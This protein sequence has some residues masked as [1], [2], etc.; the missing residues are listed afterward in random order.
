M[1][2]LLFVPLLFLFCGV[3]SQSIPQVYPEK[4]GIDSQKLTYADSIILDAIRNKAIPGAVLAVVKDGTIA[5]MKAYGNKQI[6]P[7]VISMDVNTVFDLASCTKPVATAIS[8]MILLERGQIR[9]QDK[10]SLYIPEFKQNKD[11][12]AIKKEPKI[13]DLFTHTSGFPSYAPVEELKQKY[14][15]PNPDALINYIATC[16]RDYVAETDFEY[17]CLNFITLQRIIEKVSGQSLRDFAKQ[18]IFDVLGMKHTDFNPT[19]E[20]LERVAPTEKQKDDTV[21]KG[22]VHDPLA[23]VM[24]GGISGNAGLFS[25][26]TDLAILV[27]AL[28]NGGEFNGKR[29]LSPLGVKTMRSIPQGFESFGRA[30][31]WD[32]SSDFASNKGNLFGSETYGHTGYTGTSIIID[33]ETKTSVILLTNRV[34]PEDKGEV[35][36]LRSK[37]ANIIAASIYPTTNSFTEHYYER[38][39]EFE[40][41]SPIISTDFVMIGNSLTEGGGDWN[42][43][44]NIS[45]MRNRG[46]IGDDAQGINNRLYQILPG[47]PKKIFLM[48]GINDLS[49]NLSVDSI[50]SL[51]DAMII[52][53]QTASP[54]TQIYLQSLLPINESF[55]KYKRLNDKTEL[56]PEINKKLKKVSEKRNITF[57]QLFP[58]F[59]EKNSSV[60]RKDLTSDGL[61]LNE[62]GY[63]IW[64][65]ELKQYVKTD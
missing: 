35:V 28:Q 49:H 1:K 2:K 27:S 45:N 12:F 61:H 52:K 22:I 15:A 41:E 16:K 39:A 60:L 4:V 25:D 20:T 56:I 17:S 19:G 5:Y 11:S 42:K 32:V 47:K 48:C 57:V 43:R 34:H 50:T 18:N 46:I 44:L 26:A 55:G 29:I 64:V 63:N 21:L 65:K 62:N 8:A 14:G 33:P 37:I 40:K 24:N 23:R 10:V 58:L 51:I 38:K 30:L 36:N 9:L 53:I 13:V 59:V 54:K 7:S 6:F 3:F 31:G